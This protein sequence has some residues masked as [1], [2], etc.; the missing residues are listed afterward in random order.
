MPQSTALD[1]GFRC[2]GRSAVRHHHETIAKVFMDVSANECIHLVASRSDGR[3][4]FL[5]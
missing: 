2:V 3:N 1:R 5:R 4:V